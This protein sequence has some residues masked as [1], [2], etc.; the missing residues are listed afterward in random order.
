MCKLMSFE[1]DALHQREKPTRALAFLSINSFSLHIAQYAVLVVII[2]TVSIQV[3]KIFQ[4]QSLESFH[5]I[6]SV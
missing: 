1:S 5:H 2:I 3:F 6:T 4:F